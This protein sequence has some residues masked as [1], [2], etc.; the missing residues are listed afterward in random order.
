VQFGADKAQPLAK[1]GAPEAIG[2]RRRK[3]GV[4]ILVG[5][6]L[7]DGGILGQHGSIVEF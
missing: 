4:R 1:L 7:Q 6:I 3:L 5:D 2:S